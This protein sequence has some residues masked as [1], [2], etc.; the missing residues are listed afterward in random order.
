MRRIFPWVLIILLAG[1]SLFLFGRF[2]FAGSSPSPGDL[3]EALLD[4]RCKAAITYNGLEAEADLVRSADGSAQVTLTSPETLRGLQFDFAEDGVSLNFKGLRLE[5]DPSSFLASSM[6]SALTDAVETVL[7]GE[8]ESASTHDG[9]QLLT[10]RGE[11]GSF[12]LTLDADTGAPVSLEI[13]AL[14]LDCTFSDY[15]KVGTA[16]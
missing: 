14:E 9:R 6:A 12:T 1:A 4:F 2:F 5:V 10:A 7:R 16:E 3:R 13:P 8:I 15:A 11:T